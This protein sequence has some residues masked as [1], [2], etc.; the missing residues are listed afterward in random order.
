[1]FAAYYSKKVCQK[2]PSNAR[3]TLINYKP[4]NIRKYVCLIV[5]IDITRKKF[6][7]EK[8]KYLTIKKDHII[9]P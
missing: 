6:I 1:M 5:S 3:L 7:A 9:I 8:L 4:D 2:R